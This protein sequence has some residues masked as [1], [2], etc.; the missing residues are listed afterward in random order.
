VAT[1]QV[2]GCEAW[3]WLP[4]NG[5]DDV[6]KRNGRGEEGEAWLFSRE[7]RRRQWGE[8]GCAACQGAVWDVI[9][10]IGAAVVQERGSEVL[11]LGGYVGLEVWSV[12]QQR[13]RKA[14][15]EGMM[16]A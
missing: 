15:V 1:R 8:G 3:L 2:E 9:L 14:C 6:C 7:R 10:A 13:W 11:S 12:A 4:S 16:T 5:S